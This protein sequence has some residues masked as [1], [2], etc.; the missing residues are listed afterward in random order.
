MTTHCDVPLRVKLLYFRT[1][2]IKYEAY[3]EL[4][5]R[6]LGQG[7][8]GGYRFINKEAMSLFFPRFTKQQLIC[9]Y[10]FIARKDKEDKDYN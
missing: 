10:M 8:G 1:I 2:G 3:S 5:C 4:F 9:N 6:L 7:R